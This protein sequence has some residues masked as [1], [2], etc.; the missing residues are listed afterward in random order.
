MINWELIGLINN[1]VQIECKNYLFSIQNGETRCDRQT[2]AAIYS[3][4][5][6]DCEKRHQGGERD[7]EKLIGD[8]EHMCVIMTHK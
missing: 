7:V 3:Q 4:G 5:C 1:F 6:K 8:T 2:N